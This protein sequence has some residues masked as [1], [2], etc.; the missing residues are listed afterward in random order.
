RCR[1]HLLGPREIHDH[2]AL[3][4]RPFDPTCRER[5]VSPLE[6]L[7]QPLADLDLDPREVDGQLQLR[8]EVAVVDG[9][10]LDPHP[11]TQDLIF[12]GAEAC[13]TARHRVLN[14]ARSWEL[15]VGSLEVSDPPDPTSQFRAPNS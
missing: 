12:G 7:A 14:V 10:N 9:A 11:S 2:A 15:G 3:L 6:Q 13:H 1:E 4:H 8:I 5:Y